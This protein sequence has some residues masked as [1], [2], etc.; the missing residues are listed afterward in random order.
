VDFIHKNKAVTLMQKLQWILDIAMGMYHLHHGLS[1]GREVVHRDLAARNI[2][3]KNGRA[4]VSDFGMS[5]V[6]TQEENV[7]QTSTLEGPV[8]WEAPEALMKKKYNT[9]S[10]VFSFGVVIYEIMVEQEPWRGV[11]LVEAS[12]KVVNGERMEI[13]SDWPE[14]LEKLTRKCWHQ[15]PDLRPDF[16]AIIDTLNKGIETSRDPLLTDADSSTIS[17][18]TK[19]HDYVKTPS[20]S[21]DTKYSKTDSNPGESHYNGLSG[22][23]IAVARPDEIPSSSSN[24]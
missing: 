5:R 23:Y 16:G 13:P 12:V 7:K 11:S 9:K 19:P 14:F 20:I 10:D 8:K 22:A 21:S 6:K 1:G 4:L 3:I 18:V 15:N 17:E 24:S 2:L